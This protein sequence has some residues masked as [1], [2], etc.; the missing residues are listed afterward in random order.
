MSLS[1]PPQ[2][3]LSHVG[4]GEFAELVDERIDSRKQ[5]LYHSVYIALIQQH[6]LKQ[7]LNAEPMLT[8]VGSTLPYHYYA[9]LREA[10]KRRERTEGDVELR[11]EDRVGIARKFELKRRDWDRLFGRF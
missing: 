3:P 10:E 1:P 5:S 2:S 4:L 9:I 7:H 6:S 11:A 8:L